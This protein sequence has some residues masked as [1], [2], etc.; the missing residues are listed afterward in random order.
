MSR[1]RVARF[2]LLVIT[3]SVAVTAVTGGIAL[4]AGSLRP[5]GRSVVVPSLEHLEGSHFD[6]YLLPGVLLAGIVGGLHVL[7]VTAVLAGM[8]RAS[9][10]VAI[11]GY[12][13]VIWIVV[14]MT[15]VPSGPLQM[16]C[17]AA[18]LAEIGLVLL[19]LGMVDPGSGPRRRGE[20]G[21]PAPL[22]PAR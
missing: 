3:G 11:A 21:R 19:V 2:L 18:G 9:L 15:I 22:R 1:H 16:I 10:A 5:A 12:A 14:Q 4:A 13:L 17:A 6:S 20:P 7:A 8:R